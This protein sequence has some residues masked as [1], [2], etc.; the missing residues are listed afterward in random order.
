MRYGKTCL[1][2]YCTKTENY[3]P[4]RFDIIEYTQQ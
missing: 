2:Y 4:I 3:F 1:T